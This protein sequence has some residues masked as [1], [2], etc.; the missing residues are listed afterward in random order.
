VAG[1]RVAGGG[2]GSSALALSDLVAAGF[3]DASLAAILPFARVHVTLHVT[4]LSTVRR[5]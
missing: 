5:E 3:E 1:V 2:A 4:L